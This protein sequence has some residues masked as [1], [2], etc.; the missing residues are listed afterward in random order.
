MESKMSFTSGG[1][2]C[3]VTGSAAEDD[4][5]MQDAV[6]TEEGSGSQWSFLPKPSH[7]NYVQY[8]TESSNYLPKTEDMIGSNY[9]A[10]GFGND[11]NGTNMNFFC[12]D[13]GKA[14]AFKT[15]VHSSNEVDIGKQVGYWRPAESEVQQEAMQFESTQH[16]HPLY[17]ESPASW[18]PEAIGDNP[19]VSRLDPS[20]MAGTPSFLPKPARQKASDRQRRQ[21]IADNLKALHDL[22]PN[23][24]EELSGSRLQAESTA[25]P[26]VFHEQ[27]YGHYIDQQKLNEPLEE[28]M[29]KLLEENPA[30]A[31]QLLESNG[32][33][34]LPME[35]VQDLHQSMQIFGNG[36]ALV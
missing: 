22:L 24:A 6:A 35:L 17:P 14:Y 31:S 27:G 11:A 13:P 30:S 10:L 4:S 25:I 29:G 34:L 9:A 32:L 7:H 21:R 3:H 15:E 1:T 8:L 5:N 2:S 23:Q 18:T 12:N 16:H 33:V 20:V 19:N 36:N 28:M 26:L